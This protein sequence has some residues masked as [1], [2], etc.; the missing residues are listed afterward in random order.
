MGWPVYFMKSPTQGTGVFADR[1]IKKGELVEQ[2]PVIVLRNEDIPE[3]GYLHRYTFGAPVNGFSLLVLGYGSLYNHSDDPN[4]KVHLTSDPGIHEYVAER[5][6]GEGEELFINYW[7]DRNPTAKQQKETFE[8]FE[9]MAS[10]IDEA[11][12]EA[13]TR[14]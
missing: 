7:W 3:K 6:I 4:V 8:K 1:K 14:S 10:E 5:D 2:C 12:K 11:F 9:K 13:G